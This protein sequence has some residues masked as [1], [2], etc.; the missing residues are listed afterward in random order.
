MFEMRAVF[1]LFCGEPVCGDC[2]IFP[3][4]KILIC[5]HS[6][7]LKVNYLKTTKEFLFHSLVYC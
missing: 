2:Y 7:S 4:I 1:S 5:R 6:F 3:T